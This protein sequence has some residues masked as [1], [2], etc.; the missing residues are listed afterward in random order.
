[1]IL[2]PP[3]HLDRPALRRGVRLSTDPR[4]GDPVLLFPEGALLMNGTAA[5]I[6]ACCDG[7][8]TVTSIVNALSDEYRGACAEDVVAL[9]DTLAGQHLIVRNA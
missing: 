4:T 8:R 2:R 3:V 9:I 7:T 1:M 6:V 5:R